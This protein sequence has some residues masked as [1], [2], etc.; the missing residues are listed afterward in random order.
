M[1]MKTETLT[2]LNEM[3]KAVVKAFGE[4]Q[5]AIIHASQPILH[6]FDEIPNWQRK[7]WMKKE[8]GKARY[9][10]AYKRRGKK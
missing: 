3:A 4:F 1:E 8:R 6:F 9:E 10:R 2:A 7:L 5:Y